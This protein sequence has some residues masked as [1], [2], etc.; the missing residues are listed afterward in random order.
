MKG[1]IVDAPDYRIFRPNWPNNAGFLEYNDDIFRASLIPLSF[2]LNR[3][4]VAEKLLLD[5]EHAA[6]WIFRVEK[7]INEGPL[8]Y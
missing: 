7:L 6:S 3:K 5:W 8:V 2:C 4:Y 1:V